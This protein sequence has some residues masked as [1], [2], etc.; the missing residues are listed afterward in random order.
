[1]RLT[2]F[3]MVVALGMGSMATSAWAGG[4]GTGTGTGTGASTES[5]SSSSSDGGPSEESGDDFCGS[6]SD[7]GEPV[8]ITSPADGATVPAD[9]MLAFEVTYDCSCDTCGC[10]EDQPESYS[11]Y[12]DEVEVLDCFQDCAGMHTTDLLLTPGSHEILV[13]A[14]YS[15]HGEGATIT[16]NVTGEAGTTTTAGSGDTGDGGGSS[17]SGGSGSGGGSGEGSGGNGGCRVGSPSEGVAMAVWLLVLGI[18][19]RRL[20]PRLERAFSRAS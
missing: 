20:G 3:A 13:F 1:M 19:R 12:V 15:F 10:Y 14:N 2:S 11:I 8:V 6:C 16:V 5:G 17:S 7:P 4:T 9:L 18:H